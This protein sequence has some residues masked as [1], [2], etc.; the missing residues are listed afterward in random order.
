LSVDKQMQQT[1]P[2]AINAAVE[3]EGPQRG[4][5]PRVR[6]KNS[7]D[8]YSD[9]ELCAL[10][11]WITSDGQLRTDEELVECL[12]NELPFKRRGSRIRVRLE[13]VAQSMRQ[14]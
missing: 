14:L 8:D 5:K 12:F 9:H 10:A 6:Q 2:K 3:D 11:K 7:I 13:R 1:A 4:P